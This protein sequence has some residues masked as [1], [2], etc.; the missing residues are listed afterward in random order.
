MTPFVRQRLPRLGVLLGALVSGAPYANRD[1]A[2]D[3]VREG[4]PRYRVAWS[5]D[6]AIRRNL[7]AQ[8]ADGRIVR[9][10]RKVEVPR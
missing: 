9:A 8:L 7:L 5:L 3:H 4:R 10:Y 2:I 1:A 6:L